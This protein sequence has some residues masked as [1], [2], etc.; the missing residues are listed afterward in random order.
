MET[1]RQL[2]QALGQV[3]DARERVGRSSDV[4]DATREQKEALEFLEDRVQGNA[5]LLPLL[6]LQQK[7]R[8][9]GLALL[10]GEE[11]RIKDLIN[12]QANLSGV[13]ELQKKLTD[14][15]KEAFDD[16]IVDGAKLSDVLR[17]IEQEL[18]QL[19]LRRAVLDP[20]VGFVGGK[21][22]SAT[23]SIFRDLENT[24][25][26]A[27]TALFGGGPAAPFGRF[28]DGTPI[29]F[30][31]G[32]PTPANRTLLVGEKGPE[33]ASFGA[34]GF[35]MDAARTARLLASGGGGGGSRDVHIHPGAVVVNITGAEPDTARLSGTQIGQDIAEQLIPLLQQV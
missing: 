29:E 32:G 24:L 26:N 3:A 8:R 31:H 17:R 19:V 30:A 18:T 13:I 7:L 34:P 16:L 23:G 20:L 10:P 15:L 25:G 28:S 4:R 27:L 1:V 12:E 21:V 14:T 6:E 11:R 33:L 9:Q 5:K 35:I 22:Q 2:E